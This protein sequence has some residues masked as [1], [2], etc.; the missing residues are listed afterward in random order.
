ML[1][2]TTK[3]D[4]GMKRKGDTLNQK[5]IILLTTNISSWGRKKPFR[6]IVA[7][8]NLIFTYVYVLSMLFTPVRR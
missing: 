8:K 3:R 5:I 6:V 2:V 4:S 7:A 1:T